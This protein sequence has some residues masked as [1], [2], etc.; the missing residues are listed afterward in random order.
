VYSFYDRGID[1]F[2]LKT[3]SG[4]EAVGYYGLSYKIYGNLI[5]GAA[6]LMN[7]LFPIIS[8]IKNNNQQINLYFQKTFSFLLILSLVVVIFFFSFSSSIINIISGSQ[9]AVSSPILKILVIALFFSYLNHLCGY[10]LVALSEQKIMLKFSLIALIV[11][12][13]FNFI[14]IPYFSYWAASVV[15]VL[16]EM[17]M[18]IL[19]LNYLKTKH[20]LSFKLKSLR[21]LFDTIKR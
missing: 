2:F 14:F 16:T 3:F 21:I 12:L 10:L 6:Y 9:Y 19:S 4:A 11:N 18:L 7:S 1:S 15:T 13:I 8:S 17:V 20:N 5:L